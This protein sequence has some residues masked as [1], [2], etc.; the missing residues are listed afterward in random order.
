MSAYHAG[1]GITNQWLENPQYSPDGETLDVIPYPD[2]SQY[3]ESVLGPYRV[4]QR[5]Y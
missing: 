1:R 3:V 4:Y 5:L 2:T